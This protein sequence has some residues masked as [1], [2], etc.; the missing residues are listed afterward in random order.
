MLHKN[1]SNEE[2]D[3]K[4]KKHQ[5]SASCYN[6]FR[7]HNHSSSE[8]FVGIRSYKKTREFSVSQTYVN[9]KVNHGLHCTK[10]YTIWKSHKQR[11]PHSNSINQMNT[12]LW[13]VISM[14]RCNF[15]QSLKIL[16][17]GFRATL[18]FSKI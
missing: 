1:N 12:N 10:N 11:D 18:K 15:L 5:Q 16:W 13:I 14:I 7:S 6:H 3:N 9:Y 2:L 8:S 4:R 17:R